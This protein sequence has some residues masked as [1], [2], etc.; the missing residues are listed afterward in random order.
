MLMKFRPITSLDV[1]AVAALHI[2]GIK[3]GFI[4]SLGVDFVMALYE[5]IAQSRTS[6]GFVARGNGKLY[7]KK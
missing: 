7:R 4:S 1:S 2:E 5:S 6:F 3:T